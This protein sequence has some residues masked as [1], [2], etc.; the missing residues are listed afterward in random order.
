MT[1]LQALLE[2]APKVCLILTVGVF[3]GGWLRSVFTRMSATVRFIPEGIRSLPFNWRR[4]LFVQDVL[5]VPEII[6]GYYR[7][8]MVNT[9]YTAAHIWKRPSSDRYVYFF[10][11][12]ILILPAY[13]YRVCIKSTFWA[14]SPLVYITRDYK[15]DRMPKLVADYVQNSPLAGC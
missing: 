5:N 13:A 6:P 8:D 10:Y 12:I 11:F 1:A 15:Y 14:Y 7:D 9:S 2:G 3:F 4:T